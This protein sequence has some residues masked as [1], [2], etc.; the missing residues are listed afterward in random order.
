MFP[1]SIPHRTN[2]RVEVAV[3]KTYL[4]LKRTSAINVGS[5]SLLGK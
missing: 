5:G 3:G 2:A 1:D 4:G